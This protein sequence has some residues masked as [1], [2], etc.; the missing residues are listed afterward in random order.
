MLRPHRLLAVCII[1]LVPRQPAMA[2]DEAPKNRIGGGLTVASATARS[3]QWQTGPGYQ[4]RYVRRV[5][6]GL[7]WAVEVGS[8]SRNNE[9]PGPNDIV[10]DSR[11]FAVAVRSPRVLQTGSLL[12]SVQFQSDSGW[13]VRPGFGFGTHVFVAYS[14]DQPGPNPTSYTGHI[15][16]EAGLAL[17]VAAGREWRLTRFSLA[18]E[19]FFMAS[20]G[21]D[22]STRAR[23][24]IGIQ[25]AP[26]LAF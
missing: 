22:S 5:N 26:L 19:G 7:A 11:G 23:R 10:I 18:I 13:L 24:T 21:E 8:Y 4:V 6:D 1:V 9:Q 16:S 12:G 20:G 17:A 25:I 14:P 3:G 2:Q 15:G